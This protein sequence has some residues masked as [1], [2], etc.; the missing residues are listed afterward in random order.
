VKLITHLHLNMWLGIHGSIPPLP[1]MPSYRA[2][3][4]LYL[5][6]TKLLLTYKLTYVIG[7]ACCCKEIYHSDKSKLRNRKYLSHLSQNNIS[8]ILHKFLEICNTHLRFI[9]TQ[10]HWCSSIRSQSYDRSISYPKASS[11]QHAIECFVPV[12]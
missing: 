2:N 3:E 12:H 7:R 5:Y 10:L 11:P 4:Q 6:L 8:L 9:P 1:H